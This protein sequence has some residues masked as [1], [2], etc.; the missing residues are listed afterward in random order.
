[1]SPTPRSRYKGVCLSRRQR[2]NLQGEFQDQQNVSSIFTLGDVN[3]RASEQHLGIVS[4]VK[5]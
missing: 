3:E 4:F 2:G 5:F 1:M